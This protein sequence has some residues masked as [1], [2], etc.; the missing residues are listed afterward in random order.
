MFRKRLHPKPLVSVTFL[1]VVFARSLVPKSRHYLKGGVDT[2]PGTGESPQLAAVD[3][4]SEIRGH[5][6]RRDTLPLESTYRH[7]V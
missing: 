5:E 4:M 3:L 6:G 2:R 1:M 7:I